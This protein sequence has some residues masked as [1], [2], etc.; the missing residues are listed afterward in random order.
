MVT[1]RCPK[2]Y[3]LREMRDNEV[4]KFEAFKKSHGHLFQGKTEDGA[5]LDDDFLMLRMLR[6]SDWKEKAVVESLKH[7]KEF[8]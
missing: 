2:E 8:R 6:N 3:F 4:E 1:V 7:L 5:F